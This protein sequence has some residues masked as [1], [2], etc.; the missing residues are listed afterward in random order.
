MTAQLPS[1][2]LRSSSRGH[3]S[4]QQQRLLTAQSRYQEQP[5]S[6]FN[7]ASISGIVCLWPAVRACLDQ[8]SDTHRCAGP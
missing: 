8:T 2:T 7:T 3:P 4:L 6:A 1:T 5:D